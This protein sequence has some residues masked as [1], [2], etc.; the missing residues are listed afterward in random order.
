MPPYDVQ[1][2]DTLATPSSMTRKAMGVDGMGSRNQTSD[3]EGP[4]TWEMWI[5]YA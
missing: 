3:R 5:E 2:H 1:R 4:D